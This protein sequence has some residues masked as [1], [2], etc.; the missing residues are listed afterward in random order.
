M[1]TDLAT[2]VRADIWSDVA[3]PFCYLGKRKLEAAAEQAGIDLEVTYHSFQL[4][5]E[6]AVDH[7]GSHAEMLGGK[8]SMPPEQVREVE[9][10]MR[11]NFAEVGLVV[12]HDQIKIV[13]TGKAHELLHLALRHGVQPALK[14]RL[15]KAYFTDGLNVADTDTLVNLGAEVGLDADEVRATLTDGR[16]ADA[17]QADIAQARQYGITG[18]PFFVL[19]SKFGVSGAQPVEVFADVLAQVVAAR[20]GSVTQ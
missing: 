14:E 10:Q 17:V 5:P 3:C 19:D 16:Y 2:A 9:A 12:N 18:V 4:A 13:N 15:L 7:V 6:L 1:S 8:F 11:G 20:S